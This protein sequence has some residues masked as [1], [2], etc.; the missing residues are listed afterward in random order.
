MESVERDL[1]ITD[2]VLTASL[3]LLLVRYMAELCPDKIGRE[4]AKAILESH[5]TM[6]PDE[7][8]VARCGDF[9]IRVIYGFTNPGEA[10]H[11]AALL[12]ATLLTR[13]HP[14]LDEALPEAWMAANRRAVE[15]EETVSKDEDIVK[16]IRSTGGE[17]TKFDA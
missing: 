5:L 8:D 11:T 4:Y 7:F 3:V 16:M 6:E 2:K 13:A 1:E 14:E 15:D 17:R 12:L 10:T 9:L